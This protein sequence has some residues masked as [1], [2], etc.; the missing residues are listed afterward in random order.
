[1]IRRV[2]LALVLLLTGTAAAHAAGTCTPASSGISFGNFT[3]SQISLIGSITLTCTG[4][5]NFNYT[6]SLNTGSSGTYSPRRMYNGANSLTYNLYRDAAYTQIFG[7]GT[8]GSNTVTGLVEMKGLPA[9]VVTIS[10]YARLPTQ[11]VPR[12][13]TYSDTIVASAATSQGT[14]IGSFQVTALVQGTCTI[15]ATNLTFGSYTGVQLDGQSQISLTCTNGQSWNIGLNQGT[16][17][18]A[19][20][21]TRKM[22]GPGTASMNYSLYRNSTRTLNWGNTV[23]TDTLAGTGTGSAQTL[24]VYGRVPA[25]QTLPAGGYED[26]IIATVTF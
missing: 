11:T 17:P 16:F 13:G 15:S 4:S 26:T 2:L 18:G 19:T 7:D 25:S 8:G 24:P 9:Q 5:G 10:I 12:A 14:Q 1:M 3:G 6:V 23:G 20:V 21:T 22:T